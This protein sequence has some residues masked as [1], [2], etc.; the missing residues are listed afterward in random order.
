MRINQYEF[1]QNGV[2]FEPT[3][4]Q[5]VQFATDQ[6]AKDDKRIAELND[7]I[8]VKDMLI[9]QLEN[10]NDK[11]IEQRDKQEQQSAI[12]KRALEL[13]CNEIQDMYCSDY[14]ICTRD[15]RCKGKCA[16][17]KYYN[18]EQFLDQ[19]KKELEE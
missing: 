12:Y 1:R 13:A 17:E 3:K 6:L 10:Q 14:C 15:E 16:Y 9:E 7:A 4:Q 18:K 8:K 19:A 5:I 11:L 2:E